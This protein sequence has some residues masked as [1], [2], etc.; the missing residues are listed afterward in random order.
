MIVIGVGCAVGIDLIREAGLVIEI[1]SAERIAILNAAEIG[2]QVGIE[3]CDLTIAAVK[4]Q[5]YN[6]KLWMDR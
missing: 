3:A 6:R 1:G 2:V 5:S 4:E